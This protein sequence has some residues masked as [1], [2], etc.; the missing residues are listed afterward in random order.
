MVEFSTDARPRSMLPATTSSDLTF[1]TISQWMAECLNKHDHCRDSDSFDRT[2]SLKSVRFLKLADTS[3]TLVDSIL[4]TSYVCLSYCWGVGTSM[5]KTTTENIAARKEAGIDISSLPKVFQDA[6]DIC[7]KF[8]VEYLWIDSLCIVQDDNQDWIAQSACMADIYEHGRFTIFA[9]SARAPDD[10]CYS[11]THELYQGT[12]LPAYTNVYVRKRPK[13][14]ARPDGSDFPLLQRAWAYQEIC[15]S[16]R[17]ILYGSE[18]VYWRCR[19]VEKRQATTEPFK[20]M[21]NHVHSNYH[22]HPQDLLTKQKQSLRLRDQFPYSSEDVLSQAWYSMVETYTRKHLTYATDRLPALAAMANGQRSARSNDEYLAGLWKG[23]ILNDLLWHVTARTD[24]YN[25]NRG[26]S[27]RPTNPDLPTWSWARKEHAV[28]WRKD[29]VRRLSNVHVLQTMCDTLGPRIIGRVTNAALVVLQAPL[30]PL[31]SMHAESKSSPDE[32]S[33]ELKYEFARNRILYKQ[34]TNKSVR[35]YNADHLLYRPCWDSSEM[36]TS[37]PQRVFAL[38][39]VGEKPWVRRGLP[40]P[41]LL[42]LMI[43]KHASK[44]EYVRVGT[45]EVRH[46]GLVLLSNLYDKRGVRLPG[47]PNFGRPA[48]RRIFEGAIDKC[49]KR[50]IA[51]MES[52]ET[53]VATLV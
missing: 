24:H 9:L 6:I 36:E 1:S 42:T 46:V 51:K 27:T 17:A 10:G 48:G 53:Q 8:R 41:S 39:L 31:S 5:P 38:P 28:R 35:K 37:D 16:P 45:V 21:N 19:T 47:E 13:D 43:Q 18:E 26:S 50:Q 49:W 34:D 4:P 12:R 14:S 32:I 33:S 44:D 30:I 2:A 11:V 40:Y 22:I 52:M 15:L 3:V 20:A 7:K 23:T 25:A 29:C